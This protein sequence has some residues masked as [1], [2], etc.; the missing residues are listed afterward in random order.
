MMKMLFKNERI[1]NLSN[2]HYLAYPYIL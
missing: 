1:Q 2:F